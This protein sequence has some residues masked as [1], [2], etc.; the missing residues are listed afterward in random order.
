MANN[1]KALN[2]AGLLYFWQ[3]IKDKFTTKTYVDAQDATKFTNHAQKNYNC[4]TCYDE[5][6]YLVSQGSNCPSGSQYGSLF[7]MPYRQPTGNSKPD[8]CV[9]LFLPNG[10]DSKPYLYYRTSHRDAWDAWQIL[11]RGDFKIVTS[12]SAP[13]SADANTIT[14]VTN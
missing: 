10:D 12:T 5:G 11:T 8:F 13:T 9:Q 14:I 3:L 7:V 6:V 4:N 1:E 2:N